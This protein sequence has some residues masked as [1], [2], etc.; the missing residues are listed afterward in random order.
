MDTSQSRI[1]AQ[2]ELFRALVRLFPDPLVELRDLAGRLTNTSNWAAD[3]RSSVRDKKP[4]RSRS[5]AARV[6]EAKIRV[7]ALV[8]EKRQAVDLAESIESARSAS[9]LNNALNDWA[10]RRHL[11]ALLD[12]APHIARYWAKRPNEAKRLF[13]PTVRLVLPS[14]RIDEHLELHHPAQPVLADSD[15]ESETDFLER[16]RRHYQARAEARLIQPH[17]HR[18][19]LRQHAEWYMRNKIQEWSAERIATELTTEQGTP[20]VSTITKG[21]QR[22]AELLHPPSSASAIVN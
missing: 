9:V 5:R 18:R 10:E 11:H 2:Y 7:R 13:F 21:I 12:L 20:D 14:P 17:H 3:V 1:V 19:K 22:F 4:P 8:S 16:A 15:Y 6:R